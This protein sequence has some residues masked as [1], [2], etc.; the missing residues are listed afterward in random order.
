VTGQSTIQNPKSKIEKST[1]HNPKP[2]HYGLKEIAKWAIVRLLTT[3]VTTKYKLLRGDRVGFGPGFQANRKLVIRGPGRVVFGANVNAWAH[4]ERN[5]LLTFDPDATIQIGSN[6]RLNGVGLM[7]KRGIT[8]GNDCIL[9]ST[10]LVD[11]DFHSIRRDRATNP[12]APVASA[13]IIVEDNVWLAGQTVVLKG[14]RIGRNSVVGFRAVVTRDVPP[15]VV[16][17]GNPAKVVRHLDDESPAMT[18]Q[19]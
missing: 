18:H 19:S 4:E 8:I 3:Y 12:D 16:V 5:V 6:V 9:G 7:A 10:L 1:I 2:I 11:T 13:P 17:A 15:D 14:V